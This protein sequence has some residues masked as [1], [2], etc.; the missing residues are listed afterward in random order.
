M[1]MRSSFE[2]GCPANR[3]GDGKESARPDQADDPQGLAG[4]AEF[5][6][7][8]GSAMTW[9]IANRQATGKHAE[10]TSHT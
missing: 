3:P 5:T 6:A 9:P 1:N 7:R 4:T 10:K 8:N 2:G